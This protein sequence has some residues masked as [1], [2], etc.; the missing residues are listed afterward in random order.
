MAQEELYVVVDHNGHHHYLLA[1]TLT[2]VDLKID[3][4][5]IIYSVQ[6]LTGGSIEGTFV[7]NP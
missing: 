6:R 2:D 3:A 7:E 4:R 5:F 1:T